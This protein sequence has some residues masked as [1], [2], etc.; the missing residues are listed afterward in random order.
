MH[1]FLDGLSIKKRDSS[2]EETK[3]E[4][5]IRENYLSNVFDE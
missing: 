5:M 3:E 1:S 2:P 4:S